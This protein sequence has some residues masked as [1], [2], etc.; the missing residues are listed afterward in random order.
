MTRPGRLDPTPEHLDIARRAATRTWTVGPEG[1]IEIDTN[2]HLAQMVTAGLVQLVFTHAHKQVAGYE[3]YWG[4]TPDGRAWLAE[5][6]TED[7]R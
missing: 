1:A 7:G 2:P 4:L 5:H 3:D 6:E